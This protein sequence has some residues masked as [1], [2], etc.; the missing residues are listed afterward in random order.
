[1]N[2]IVKKLVI[3]I[4]CVLALFIPTYLAIGSYLITK[5][6]PVDA[7]KVDRLDIADPEGQT[8]RIAA[9]EEGN[10]MVSL[11]NEMNERATK[12]DELPAQ[13]VGEPFYKVT[14]HTGN[15]SVDFK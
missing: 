12:R 15:K 11:F 6:A 14:Y 7:K 5:D 10:D 13:L 2:V 3:S 9:A 1:M 8:F 4:L